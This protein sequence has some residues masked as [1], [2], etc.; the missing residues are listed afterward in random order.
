VVLQINTDTPATAAKLFVPYPRQIR[1][2]K[3]GVI[4][5]MVASLPAPSLE[6]GDFSIYEMVVGGLKNGAHLRRWQFLIAQ[7]GRLKVPLEL[8]F[9]TAY[10]GTWILLKEGEEAATEDKMLGEV[11]QITING[12]EHS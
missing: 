9:T 5:R 7:I 4:S 1:T 6:A 10:P 2:A 3:S 12:G 8:L 11:I